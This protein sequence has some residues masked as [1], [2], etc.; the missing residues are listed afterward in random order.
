M[1]SCGDQ[2]ASSD[3]T[4]SPFIISS[5]KYNDSESIFVSALSAYIDDSC[6]YVELGIS[7]CSA[8]QEIDMVTDGAVDDS[9]PQQISF[10]FLNVTPELCEA[11][12]VIEYAFDLTDVNSLLDSAVMINL[13][14]SDIQILFAN[15]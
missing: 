15:E 3:R 14:E 4:C 11:Y 2:E 12:F 5:E 10:K 7:G 9:L 1:Y 8:D 6:L 13:S